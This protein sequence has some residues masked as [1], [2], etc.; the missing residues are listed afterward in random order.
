MVS[1]Y[2]GS[3][4][5]KK[6]KRSKSIIKTDQMCKH[7]IRFY[8][9]NRGGSILFQRFS[10]IFAARYSSGVQPAD[11]RKALRKLA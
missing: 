3:P 11:C 1:L 7:L 2:G 4:V 8:V 5:R 6:Q 10:C 9:M